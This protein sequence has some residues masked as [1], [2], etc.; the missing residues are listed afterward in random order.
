MASSRRF[1]RM[2]RHRAARVAIG[3]SAT[4]GQ[5]SAGVV[6]RGRDFMARLKLAR[7]GTRDQGTFRRELDRRTRAL[8]RALPRGTGSWGLARKLLCIFLRDCLYTTYLRNAYSLGPAEPFLEIPLDSITARRIREEVPEIPRWP[9]VKHSD[10][11]LNAAYQA[12]AALVAK[13]QGVRRVH[14]DAFWWG[15]RP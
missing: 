3:A 2:I 14:L 9:G 5:G 15:Q 12:A 11:H 13:R 1:L 10:P 6:A 7:F 8:Q 4:R